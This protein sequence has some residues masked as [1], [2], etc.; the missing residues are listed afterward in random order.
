MS[1]TPPTYAQVA[2]WGMAAV[3]SDQEKRAEAVKSLTFAVYTQKE[4]AANLEARVEQLQ[5]ENE[6]LRLKLE[7]FATSNRLTVVR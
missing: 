1:R 5:M 3:T 6:T 4:I 7:S 2:E